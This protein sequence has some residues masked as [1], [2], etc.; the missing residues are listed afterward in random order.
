[1][2]VEL[3]SRYTVDGVTPT[4]IIAYARA[5]CAEAE[6]N[7]AW[8]SRVT[9]ETR[10]VNWRNNCAANSA[11]GGL[12][13]EA[14]AWRGAGTNSRSRRPRRS[15]SSRCWMEGTRAVNPPLLASRATMSFASASPP[16][17]LF[18]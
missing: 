7:A 16:S 5:G 14:T 9:A 12:S 1:M 18:L 13:G 3:T 6:P 2:G 11:D 15:T 10:G 8:E 17:L 4:G